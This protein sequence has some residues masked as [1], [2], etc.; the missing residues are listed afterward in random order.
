MKR[1]ISSTKKIQKNFKQTKT[2]T[3]SKKIPAIKNLNL[4]IFG[5]IACLGLAYLIQVNS[6][7][8]QGYK[9]KDLEKKVV[10][11]KHSKS[12]LELEALA[13]QSV[14]NIKLKM[15]EMGMVA[16]NKEEFLNAKPVAV[17]R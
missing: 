3:Y 11:L 6:L 4:W 5:F 13:L 7:A 8:T 2:G 1:Y 17:N 16:L 9:I 15:D 12:D 14:G 10:E